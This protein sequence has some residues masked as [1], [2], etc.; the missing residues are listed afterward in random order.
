[1]KFAYTHR[2]DIA[3]QE[4]DS[5]SRISTKFMNQVEDTLKKIRKDDVTLFLNENDRYRL[6]TLKVWVQRYRVDLR[7]ILETLLPFW[8]Q[9]VK[10]RSRKMK[11]RG[12]NVKVSTL[13]G[14]KSEEILQDQIRKK[15]PREINKRLWISMERERI[16][17]IFALQERDEFTR[18]N[19]LKHMVDY[20][21][22]KKW[23]RAYQKVIEAESKM[24]EKID[25]EMKKRP[26]R[27]NPFT[28]WTV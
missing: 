23:A 14:K 16:F 4:L 5:L 21:D 13:V 25:T 28:D 1:M 15:L 3:E 22:P 9:F 27:G 18:K 7:F 19:G 26:Y 8:E 11:T 6:L 17:T 2:K 20:K 12:L 10:R 24:R